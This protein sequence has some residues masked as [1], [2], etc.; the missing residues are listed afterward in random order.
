MRFTVLI[1]TYDNGPVVRR[2]IRSVLRQTEQ[3][4]ELFVVGDGAPEETLT[5]VRNLAENDA[6]IRLFAYEKGERHGEALRHWTLKEATGQFVCY[7][8]DDDFWFPDHLQTMGTLLAVSDFANTR[9]TSV[10]PPW[11]IFALTGDFADQDLRV[12]MKDTLTNFFGL[13][14]SGHRMDAYRRLPEGWAPAPADVWTDLHMTRKWLAAPGMR[15]ASSPAITG[16][17]FPAA[18]WH[19]VPDLQRQAERNIWY[20]LFEDPAMVEALRRNI[21]AD[22]TPLP[23]HEVV[24]AANVIRHEKSGLAGRLRNLF[25]R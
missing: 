9:C 25:P 12:R 10:S 11:T 4:F 13:S 17:N 1:P 2:A 3:D 22:E 23:L 18:T 7:L 19:Q 16:L 21:P 20:E 24:A 14:F 8:A 6:R 15:L 5:A